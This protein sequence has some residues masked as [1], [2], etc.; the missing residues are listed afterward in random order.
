MHSSYSTLSP[1]HCHT[2]EELV[3]EKALATWSEDGLLWSRG[4]LF[5][6]GKECHELDAF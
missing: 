6:R 3:V 1:I 5:E 4:V 2:I